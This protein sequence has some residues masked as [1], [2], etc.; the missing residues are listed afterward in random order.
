MDEPAQQNAQY[1]IEALAPH[2]ESIID[3]ALDRLVEWQ[4]LENHDGEFW[5]LSRSAWHAQLRNGSEEGTAAE[6]VTMR[7]SRAIFNDEIPDPKRCH[8]HLPRQNLRCP[9]LSLSV[10]S[11]DIIDDLIAYKVRALT[12]HV[13]KVMPK[14]L[15]STPGMKRKAKSIE[16]LLDRVQSIH[17]PARRAGCPRDLA[18]D[19]LSLHASDPQFL[20][21]SNLRVRS[22][23]AADCERVPRRCA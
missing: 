9:A 4:V 16:T 17:T 8:P 11:Q 2:A 15:L 21:E 10:Y 1:W 20:P 12:T 18:D 7:I 19:L 23:G 6:F 22:L 3:L 5:T 13:M 14:F